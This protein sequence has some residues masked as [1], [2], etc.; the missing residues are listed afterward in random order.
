MQRPEFNPYHH[1]EAKKERGEERKKEERTEREKD[2]KQERERQTRAEHKIEPGM[3]L[4][5]HRDICYG[6]PHIWL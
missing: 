6:K 2:I 5:R 4:T 3:K 1:G